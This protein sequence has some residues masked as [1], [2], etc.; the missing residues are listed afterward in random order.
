MKKILFVCSA[1]KQRSKTA[2]DY[3]AE[4]LEGYEFKSAGTN[5]KVCNK[6]GTSP[7]TEELLIWADIVLLMEQ[8]H[9]D[10]INKAV[11]DNYNG[12]MNV[13]GIPD[14]FRYYQKELIAIL[15]LKC[16]HIL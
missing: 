5:I 3:F 11:G 1:N 2:E 15:N 12:K 13:L 6:E 10:L 14:K 9:K 8:K 16:D 4:K 7:L